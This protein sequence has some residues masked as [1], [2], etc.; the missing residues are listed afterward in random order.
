MP[1]EYA[2]HQRLLESEAVDVTISVYRACAGGYVGGGHVHPALLD[3]AREA[4]AEAKESG[5]VADGYV[6]RCGDDI[7]LVLLHGAPGAGRPVALDVFGKAASAGSRL[8]QHQ[9]NGGVKV[10]GTELSFLPR[11]SEPVLCLF[12]NKAPAGAWN[13]LAYRTFADPFVT[14][15]LVSDPA[16]REGFGFVVEDVAGT[17]T[18]FDVP[19]DLYELLDALRR[20]AFVTSVHSRATGEIAATVS[21]G[22]DPMIAI[23]CEQP[24]PAVEDAL[25]GFTAQASTMRVDGVLVPVSGNGDA[26]ARSVPRAMGLGF[27]VTP[28][29]LVGPRDL[30]GDAAFDDLRRVALAAA[31]SARTS[32][33]V[34]APVR[35]V[36]SPL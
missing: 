7:D 13:L 24:F 8:R 26:S 25:E 21:R 17:Q 23:R 1:K 20:G 2:S 6:A 14:P 15:G 34:A 27:Q 32:A 36:A 22:S 9:G 5:V 19:V 29:R 4:L 30:L 31:R 18:R 35:E 28:E 33:V 12:T 10:G 16:L 3:A 11:A